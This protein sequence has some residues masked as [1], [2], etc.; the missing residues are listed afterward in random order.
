[1]FG[2]LVLQSELLQSQGEV[3][4]L[5]DRLAEMSY[6]RSEMVSGKVHSELM[7]IA[8]NKTHAAET[9]A[10]ELQTEVGHSMCASLF[11]HVH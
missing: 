8:D 9:K 11:L 5:L 2:D 3:K 6:E 10:A 1:M 4:R 7:K